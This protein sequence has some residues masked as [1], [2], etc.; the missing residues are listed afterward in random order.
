M[1]NATSQEIKD[2]LLNSATKDVVTNAK[3][4]HNR[5]L[6]LSPVGYQLNMAIPLH[7]RLFGP[8]QMPGSG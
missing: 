1:P 7:Y 8:V 3:A 2:A 6:Y 5:L 4:S